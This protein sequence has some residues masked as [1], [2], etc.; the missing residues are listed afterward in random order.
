MTRAV[1][2]HWHMCEAMKLHGGE[3][4]IEDF[5]GTDFINP[6]G[7]ARVSNGQSLLVI[8]ANFSWRGLQDLAARSCSPIAG[9]TDAEELQAAME[10]LFE[11]TPASITIHLI[12]AA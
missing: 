6:L 8:D 1:A 2:D 10:R 9:T 3:L 7:F 5:F 11:L 12:E 4:T